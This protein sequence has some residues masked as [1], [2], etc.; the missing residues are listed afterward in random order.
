[1]ADIKAPM[2]FV[3]GDRDQLCRP[4]HLAD[5]QQLLRV[6][7]TSEVVPGDHSFKPRSEDVAV[8]I[9]VKWLN[10]RY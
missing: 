8:D 1:M 7:Y 3:T 10:S 5:V 2:L 4:Q 9:A 6:P